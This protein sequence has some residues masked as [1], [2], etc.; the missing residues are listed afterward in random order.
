MIMSIK[1]IQDASNQFLKGSI[2]R[3]RYLFDLFIALGKLKDDNAAV[4]RIAQQMYFIAP[5]PGDG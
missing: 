1:A 4:H 5:E 2:S 3:E